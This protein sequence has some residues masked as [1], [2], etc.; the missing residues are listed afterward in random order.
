M[1]KIT[2][3]LAV[4]FTA[5]LLFAQDK[6]LKEVQKNYLLGKIEAAKEVTDKIVADPANANSA[7][8]WLWK[9]TLD[10]VA[11]A[12]EKL[13]VTCTDCLNSSTMLF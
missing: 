2:L 8:A 12:N 6:A 10:A 13:K 7:E 5:T 3:T 11:V 1:K 9:S 4:A